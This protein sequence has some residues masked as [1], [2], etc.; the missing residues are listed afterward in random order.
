MSKKP[1]A[2]KT[3]PK[4]RTRPSVALARVSEARL[5]TAERAHVARA[6]DSELGAV[7]RRAKRA[8]SVAD[9]FRRAAEIL[10]PH[11]AVTAPF[12]DRGIR[13]EVE[14]TLMLVEVLV[15]AGAWL[16]QSKGMPEE[17]LRDKIA[18]W[19]SEQYE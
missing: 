6:L 10:A 15:T 2:K 1:K 3:K 8:S 9:A 5:S 13:P 11:F 14:D 12:V 16:A 17:E 18:G 4:K 19:V 7:G